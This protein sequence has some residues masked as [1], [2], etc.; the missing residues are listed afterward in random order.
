VGQ[1]NFF[2]IKNT[3][4]VKAGNMAHQ[5]KSGENDKHCLLE[6]CGDQRVKAKV[7][8]QKGHFVNL[9]LKLC[10][11]IPL[12]AVTNDDVPDGHANGTRVVL[13]SV[14]L[15]DV[16]STSKVLLNGLECPTA[17][18]SDVDYFVCTLET[19]SNSDPVKKKSHKAQINGV[20]CQSPPF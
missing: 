13:E 3:L 9:M 12:M 6:N 5:K 10:C 17:D 11:R 15:E 4:V 1:Q 19:V 8:G 16:I 14:V 2:F 20:C 18:A 7:M